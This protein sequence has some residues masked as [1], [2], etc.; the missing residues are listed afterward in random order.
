MDDPAAPLPHLEIDPAF[1]ELLAGH[2][3]DTFDALMQTP[4]E[5]SLHKKGLASWRQRVVLRLDGRTF[6]L[7]RFTPSA[8]GWLKRQPRDS[9]AGVEYRWIQRLTELGIACP[10]CVAFGSRAGDANHPPASLLLTAAVPGESLEKL[11]ARDP[12]DPPLRDRAFRLRLIDALAE[13]IG[14][15]H[16][17]GLF[18]RDLYLSHLFLAID[19]DNGVGEPRLTLIDLQRVIAPRL[20]QRRWWVKDLAALHYSTPASFASRTDRLRWFKRY[21]GVRRLGRAEKRL[22][23]AVLRKARRIARHSR[24]HALG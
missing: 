6:Y 17:H 23:R 5:Q 16:G 24:K 12:L 13:L 14:K 18:H 2:E 21:R 15:L 9:S 20:F 8:T 22:I 1:A 10:R 4:G 3:L 19:N 7:K 11:A